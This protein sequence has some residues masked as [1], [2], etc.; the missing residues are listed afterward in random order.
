MIGSSFSNDYLGKLV[1]TFF[2]EG[3]RI[4]KRLVGEE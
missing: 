4:E 1:S 2:L 3:V